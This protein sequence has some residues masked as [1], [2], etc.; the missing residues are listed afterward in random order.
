M[1]R[2]DKYES[3]RKQVEEE[4]SFYTHL[5]I[6]VLVI[7]AFWIFNAMNDKGHWWAFWPTFGWGIGLSFHAFG[8]FGKNAVF[9]K[10]WEER[11]MKKLMDEE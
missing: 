11:R 2:T 7:G 6:Y 4:K 10:R 3:A 1:E 5:I 8:V 9:G